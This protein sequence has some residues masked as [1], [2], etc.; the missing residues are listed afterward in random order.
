M[1]VER[2]FLLFLGMSDH[3]HTLAYIKTFIGDVYRI[4]GNGF[5]QTYPNV[6][7]QVVLSVRSAV[8]ECMFVKGVQTEARQFLLERLQ[9][10]KRLQLRHSIDHVEVLYTYIKFTPKSLEHYLAGDSV[11]TFF[12]LFKAITP[13]HFSYLCFSFRQAF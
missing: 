6:D 13:A 1:Q 9:E 8:I 3:Q 10:F 7:V 5:F 4:L 11:R 2:P 12:T